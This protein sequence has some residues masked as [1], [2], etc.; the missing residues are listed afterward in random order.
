MTTRTT[1][2]VLVF[3]EALFDVFPDGQQV[4]GGAPFNVAWN[5]HQLGAT[6]CFVGGVGRDD[7]GAQIRSAMR[8]IGMDERGLYDHPS[9]PT[10]RVD[11]HLDR[12]EPSY[13]IV[14][15]QAYDD[16]SPSWAETLPDPPAL[17]YHGTLA[18][19]AGNRGLLDHLR[20]RAR[21]R[22][23][24][25]NLR[26]PW[27]SLEDV[28][29]WVRGADVIKLN[30]DELDELMPG[31]TP[32]RRAHDLLRK[33]EVREAVIVTLGAEGAEVH[34]AHGDVVKAPAPDV[35]GFR[36]AVGAGDAFASVAII[37]LVQGWATPLILDRAL[38]FAARVCTLQGA[39]SQDAAFYHAARE[40]WE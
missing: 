26:A 10:G 37:G 29:T 8:A 38:E 40:N 11:I 22:F 2:P 7:A 15:N 33:A 36:D 20:N 17:L 28:H 13:D 16:V 27:Y 30:R 21:R 1:E 25:V 32:D 4:L 18:L 9:A 12:G 6:A 24:D 35:T 39:T 23:V 19:R 5:L 3:G 34:P 31:S 14:P